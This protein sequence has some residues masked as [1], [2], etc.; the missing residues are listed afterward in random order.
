MPYEGIS[1]KKYEE[2]SAKIKPVEIKTI[3]NEKADI[4]KFC[5]NDTCE[6]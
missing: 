6:I 5:N 2:M 1:K 3:Y 4:D